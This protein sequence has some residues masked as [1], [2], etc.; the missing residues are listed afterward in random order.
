M[1]QTI[2]LFGEAEKGTYSSLLFMDSI[3]QLSD[4]LGN[5]PK[6]TQGIHIAIQILLYKCTLVFIRV[7]EEGFS[8]K[9]Y[10]QGLTLLQN[11]HQI[12]ELTAIYLPGVG[13]T[14]IIEASAPL[15]NL[16]HSFLITTEHDFYDYITSTHIN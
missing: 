2:A 11:T 8:T 5:P 4:L 15:C 9:D 1:P 10:L 6:D 14:T 3:S 7:K 12:K 13:D 16:Y